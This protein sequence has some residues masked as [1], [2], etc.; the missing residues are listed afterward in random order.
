MSES[1]SSWTFDRLKAA[2]TTKDAFEPGEISIE[3]IGPDILEI[4]F[5]TAGQITLFM[6]V[7]VHQI[8]TTTLLWPRDEQEA[9]EAFELMMLRNHK[10]LLPLCALA[11]EQI[12]GRDYYELFG[13]MSIRSSLDSVVTEIRTLANNAI[14]LAQDLGPRSAKG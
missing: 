9:A 4:T 2:L 14:E 12:D 6:S 8:L 13:A 11:I 3:Q 1:N 10:K 5:E 7:G